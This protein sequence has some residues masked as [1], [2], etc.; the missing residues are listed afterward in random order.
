MNVYKSHYIDTFAVVI[1]IITAIQ[2]Q[3]YL[4]FSEINAAYS[5]IASMSINNHNIQTGV[6]PNPLTHLYI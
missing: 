2:Y 1:T 5:R 6:K 3:K 4:L